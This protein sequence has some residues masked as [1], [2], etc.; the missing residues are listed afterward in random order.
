MWQRQWGWF[1]G[2]G[3]PVLL[4]SK[5]A[6]Q[7]LLPFAVVEGSVLITIPAILFLTPC[8]ANLRKDALGACA[9]FKAF[10]TGDA[11][12]IDYLMIIWYSYGMKLQTIILILLSVIFPPLGVFVVVTLLLAKI[13]KTKPV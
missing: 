4:A 11:I 3:A 8:L 12:L 2:S 6:L 10:D 7:V 9:L 1:G 13:L 5:Q